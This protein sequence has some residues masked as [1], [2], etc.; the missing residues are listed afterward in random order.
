MVALMTVRFW[1]GLGIAADLVLA[2]AAAVAFDEW[3][4]KRARRRPS[5][6]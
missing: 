2:C 6:P 1:L 4:I 5:E 3:L